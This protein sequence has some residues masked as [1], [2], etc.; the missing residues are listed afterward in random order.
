[1]KEKEAIDVCPRCGQI[2]SFEQ[3]LKKD[4]IRQEIFTALVCTNCGYK[5]IKEIYT[6][7]EWLDFVSA[8]YK[9]KKENK[10]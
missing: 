9:K 6:T 2:N 5:A 8:Q 1:M 3:A 10:E 7:P 4:D